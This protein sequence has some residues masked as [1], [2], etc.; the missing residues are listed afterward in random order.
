VD[1]N[2]AAM[3]TLVPEDHAAPNHVFLFTDDP[4]TGDAAEEI[5]IV[6]DKK[7]MDSKLIYDAETDTYSRY[8]IYPK[9]ELRLW[10]DHDTEEAITFA[11]VIIQYTKVTYNGSKWAPVTTH[12]GEGNADFFMNGQHVAGYWRREDM[13]SRTVFYGPDGEE[14]P[15]QRG[16]T[17]IVII[18]REKEVS[19]K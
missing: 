4:L 7:C 16:R 18:P 12:V 17:L 11:N 19:Y 2:V 13:T 5:T 9:N 14:M 8:M 6:W 3:S 1:G 10:Q 15:L